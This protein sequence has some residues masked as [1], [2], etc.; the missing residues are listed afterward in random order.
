MNRTVLD[1]QLAELK[2]AV[3]GMGE[4]AES[5]MVN[6][7]EALET[8]AELTAF[9]P[10]GPEQLRRERQRI[11]SLAALVITL[12]QPT[13]GDLRSALGAMSTAGELEQ[14]GNLALKVTARATDEIESAMRVEPLSQALIALV[15]VAHRQL[16]AALAAY[17]TSNVAAAAAVWRGDVDVDYLYSTIVTSCKSALRAESIEVLA[18]YYHAGHC[19]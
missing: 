16:Q 17:E 18:Y 6:S 3:N 5:A 11:D 8:G 7:M 19:P 9:T 2:A 10:C 1:R 14:I 13:L 4:Q 12:H 15:R